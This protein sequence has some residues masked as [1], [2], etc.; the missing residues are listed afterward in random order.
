MAPTHVVVGPIVALPALAVVPEA[1]P[2]AALAA[3]VG[4][5]LPDVD[6][7]AGRHRKTLHFPALYWLPAAAALAVAAVTGAVAAVAA[8]A[9]FANAAV[10]SLSDWLGAGD[11]PRPWEATE[12][13]AVYLHPARRWLAAR[14]WIR[15]DGAPEDVAVALVCALPGLALYGPTVRAA[16]VAAL[17]VGVVYGLVR[18]RVPKYVEPIIE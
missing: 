3:M 5:L 16:T 9:L 2:A 4:G 10:H 14:R 13:R 11:E 8:A 1:A 18:K 7:L 12:D 15:Y 17:A 6:L